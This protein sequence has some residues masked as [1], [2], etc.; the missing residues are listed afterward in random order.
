MAR[1]ND[2]RA[3]VRGAKQ[4]LEAFEA[5]GVR[6][7][8]A[9]RR[10]A[11]PASSSE[12]WTGL[13]RDVSTCTRCPLYRTAT[14]PVFGEGHRRAKLVFVGEAPGRDEDLQGRPFV[15]AAGK[16]LTKMIEAMGLKREDVYICNVLKHRPPQN[17]L[18]EPDEAE[19]CLPYL[20]QQLALIRPTVICTLGAVAAR[21]LLGPEASISKIRG[22]RQTFEGVALIPTYHPAYLLR[23]PPAKRLVWEDLK[24]VKRLLEA[25]SRKA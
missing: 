3:A 20:L 15:G 4:Q 18:P 2:L 24:H 25:A 14:H 21:A 6:D 13:E 22:Q 7:V 19:A 23:N 10:N 9:L 1:T 8:P 5:W 11:S 12:A 16:L 17:R